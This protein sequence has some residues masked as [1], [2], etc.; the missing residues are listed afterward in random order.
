VSHHASAQS[1]NHAVTV[2]NDGELA[3]LYYD[4]ARNDGA[5]GIPTDVYLR[6]SGNGGKTWSAPQ[7]LA[8]FDLAKAPIARGY[9]VG[10]YQ[11]L[12]AIGPKGLLAFFGVAGSTPGS[13]DVLSVRLDR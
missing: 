1:F 13:A 12:E 6:H 11:G 9:F 4:D 10:D 8:S 7:Q 5:P 3:V 2:G